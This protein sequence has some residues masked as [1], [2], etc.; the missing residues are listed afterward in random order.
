MFRQPPPASFFELFWEAIK[1]LI[2]VVLIIAALVSLILGILLDRKV[3][4]VAALADDTGPQWVDGLAIIIVVII[5][6]FVT[7]SW[8]C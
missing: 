1:E 2:M 8:Y 4:P 7:V 6:G 5:I 3:I